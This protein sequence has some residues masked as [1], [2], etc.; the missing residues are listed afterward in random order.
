V[1]VATTSSGSSSSC[2][3]E[4]R[5]IE[6]PLDETHASASPPQ[7]GAV[8]IIGSTTLPTRL[9]PWRSTHSSGL[10]H[11]DLLDFG[12]SPTCWCTTGRLTP[13]LPRSPASIPV[14]VRIPEA[15]DSFRPGI[16]STIIGGLKELLAATDE[17][18][19]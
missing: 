13:R 7:G 6:M 5:L 2:C 17:C 8:Q 4:G 18:S 11:A 19:L 12:C 3:D 15:P 1:A 10:P 16:S 14:L 9:S